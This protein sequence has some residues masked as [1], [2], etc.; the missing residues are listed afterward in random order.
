MNEVGKHTGSALA[1]DQAAFEQLMALFV[2]KGLSPAMAFSH[3]LVPIDENGNEIKERNLIATGH[4]RY[5]LV[6]RAEPIDT[7]DFDLE[8]NARSVAY[9]VKSGAELVG[10]DKPRPDAKFGDEGRL[11]DQD[12]ASLKVGEVESWEVH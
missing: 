10:L 8:G 3:D 2:S 5:K 7:I 12:C 11:F 6:K 9:K 1:T 4:E